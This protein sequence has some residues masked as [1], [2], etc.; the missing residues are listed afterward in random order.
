VVGPQPAETAID[1]LHDIAPGAAGAALARDLT[2]AELCRDHE[3]V[4]LATQGL[5]DH[6]LARAVRLAVDVGRVDHRDT[7]VAG[8]G[9]DVVHPVLVD[10]PRKGVGADA[11]G[12]HPQARA[13]QSPVRHVRHG[14]D[15][16]RVFPV[17]DV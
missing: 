7:D 6:L 13:A 2:P 3:L 15:P 5:A 17:V 16:T 11:D 10:A 1:G 9:Q 12:A 14:L 8:R 4:A